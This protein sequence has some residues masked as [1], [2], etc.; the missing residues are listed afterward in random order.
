[1]CFH[2]KGGNEKYP[3]D[4]T[5]YFSG[6][7][8]TTSLPLGEKRF[9]GVGGSVDSWR[10]CGSTRSWARQAQRG[11]GEV[12]RARPSKGVERPGHGDPENPTAPTLRDQERGW[13][14][15]RHCFN[16]GRGRGRG[17]G[18]AWGAGTC[19]GRTRRGS[20]PA[21]QR[22]PGAAVPARGPRCASPKE[23][24]SGLVGRGKT[25]NSGSVSTPKRGGSV[26][27]KTRRLALSRV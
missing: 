7:G 6:H 15:W 5:F 9:S 10:D 11:I 27:D 3:S 2:V 14:Y 13:R 19:G 23:G 16:P 4:F 18:P 22:A 20:R 17:T 8:L 1:M 12:A 21:P 24:F 25:R 26:P